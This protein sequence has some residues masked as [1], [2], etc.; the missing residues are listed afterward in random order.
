M[1]PWILIAG[2]SGLLAVVFNAALDHVLHF[3]YGSEQYFIFTTAVRYQIWH[4]FALLA[5]GLY[6]TNGRAIRYNA[7]ITSTA[8]LFT[9]GILFFSGGIYLHLFTH[10]KQF[11]YIVPFGGFAYIIAWFLLAVYGL[12]ILRQSRM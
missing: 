3:K 10:I 1:N 8:I 2:I 6:Q 5:L 9:V 12:L 11:V 4:S 7:L